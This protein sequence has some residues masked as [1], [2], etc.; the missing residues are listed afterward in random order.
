VLLV[1]YGA[2]L[3]VCSHK[4]T[5]AFG[6]KFSGTARK[7]GKAVDVAFVALHQAQDFFKFGHGLTVGKIFGGSEYRL[8]FV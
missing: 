5:A 3:L 4:A 7:S 8:I 1:E 2:E 6:Y